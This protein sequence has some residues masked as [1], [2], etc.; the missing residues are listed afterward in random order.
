MSQTVA[1]NQNVLRRKLIDQQLKSYWVAERIGVSTKT[2]QRWLS[3]KAK[4]AK[5]ENAIGLAKVLNCSVDDLIHGSDHQ[6]IDPELF[7]I[8]STPSKWKFLKTIVEGL[9]TPHQ[10][11]REKAQ[12][13]LNLSRLAIYQLDTESATNFAKEAMI[14]AKYCSDEYLQICSSYLIA[15]AKSISGEYF[16][17]EAELKSLLFAYNKLE[18]SHEAAAVQNARAFNFQMWR[19]SD[20]ATSTANQAIE[21]SQ[22]IGNI[23]CEALGLLCL[24]QVSWE[25]DEFENAKNYFGQSLE[26]AQRGGF[27]AQV[28]QCKLYLADIAASKND[29]ELAENLLAEAK[30]AFANL[31]LADDGLINI[32][33][34]HIEKQRGNLPLAKEIYAEGLKKKLSAYS[35][36]YILAQVRSLS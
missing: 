30:N 20:K 3:G 26:L 24:G 15:L 27:V 1:I 8:V 33:S 4:N 28:N 12:M 23:Q 9:F 6:A 16:E 14:L 18:K 19:N 21:E 31:E 5:Q 32:T 36:E 34:A 10:E 11:K 29:L 2:M 25:K 13:N 22:K 7:S 17:A 35:R